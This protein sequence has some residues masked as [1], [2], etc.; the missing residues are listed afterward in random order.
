MCYDV[1]MSFILAVLLINA[2]HRFQKAFIYLLKLYIIVFNDK[3]PYYLIDNK[4]FK[5]Y[6]LLHT[7]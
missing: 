4:N 3:R 5:K 1:C 2:S 6:Y 7:A